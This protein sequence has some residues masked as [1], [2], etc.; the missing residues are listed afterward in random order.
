MLIESPQALPG[1]LHFD[2]VR[3]LRPLHVVGRE[4][5]AELD[6]I[7]LHPHIHHAKPRRLAAILRLPRKGPDI[8]LDLQLPIPRRAAIRRYRIARVALRNCVKFPKAD[9]SGSMEDH[10]RFARYAP[11]I[12]LK[13]RTQFVRVNGRPVRIGEKCVTFI[14][15]GEPP[16]LPAKTTA[17]LS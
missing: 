4:F 15:C 11:R 8:S 7:R 10:F 16:G 1:R 14:K 13:A 6:P 2:A 12:K 3:R 5:L 17:P 9:F